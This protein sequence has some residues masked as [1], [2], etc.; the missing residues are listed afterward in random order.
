M[1][2][3]QVLESRLKG[4]A[5][6]MVTKFKNPVEYINGLQNSV[7]GITCLDLDGKPLA[8]TTKDLFKDGF[9]DIRTNEYSTL[10][11]LNKESSF[12]NENI[13]KKAFDA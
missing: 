7:V 6:L 4:R 11:D 2:V 8:E 9:A 1:S 5:F 10:E 13:D 3:I 12:D